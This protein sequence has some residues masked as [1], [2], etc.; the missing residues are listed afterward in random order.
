MSTLNRLDSIRAI[1]ERK[2]DEFYAD[3]IN[4]ILGPIA[5]LHAR[6]RALATA[7]LID[8]KVDQLAV[9]T[10]AAEQ[11]KVVMAIDASRREAKARVRL[12]ATSA[13]VMAIVAD[14][15]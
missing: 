11:D 7:D 12:G 9:L 4:A 10:N 6:K 5:P 13:N 8:D 15:H 1:A 14:L 2:V 3:R